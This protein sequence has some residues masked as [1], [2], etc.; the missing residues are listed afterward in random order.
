MA[1][2]TKVTESEAAAFLDQYNLGQLVALTPIR[3][4]IENSNY[5]LDTDSGRYVLTLFEKRVKAGELPFFLGLM[6]HLAG[7]D[8]PCPRPIKN[9][10]GAA[11]QEL[12]K[13]PA[14]LVSRLTGNVLEYITPDH[15]REVGRALAQLHEA[16]ADCPWQR[17]NDMALTCWQELFAQC[18]D[19]A[20]SVQQGLAS[21]LQNELDALARHWPAHLPHGII[22][23]DLF[24]DN[25]FFD[26][27][28]FCGMFDFYFACND[29][30]AYDLVITINAWCFEHQQ[31]FNVTKAKALVAGY[32]E[33]RQLSVE[34]IQALP[35]LA[36]GACIRFLMTRLYDW[37][38]PV[39]NALVRPKNPLD[40]LA[41]LRFHQQV[42]HPSA[43]GLSP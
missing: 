12:N 16:G 1:V 30:L 3:Q 22:H 20:D 13:R 27:D 38:H 19:R 35:L 6:E 14:C 40:Y 24:P 36:R 43:Y 37:L 34:E 17:P 28:K 23:A 31:A 32:Q 42:K 29:L 2:Y 18:A 10:A 4:G 11:L 39:P 8:L 41:R 9:K 7:K 21:V 33:I 25:V 15:C 5:F 26:G